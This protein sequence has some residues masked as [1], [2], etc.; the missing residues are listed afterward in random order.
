[1]TYLRFLFVP[2]FLSAGYAAPASAQAARLP[3]AQ[4]AVGQS[5]MSGG[6]RSPRGFPTH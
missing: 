4:I 2:V 6:I 1:M 3:Y 5:S